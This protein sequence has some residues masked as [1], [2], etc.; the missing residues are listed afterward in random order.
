MQI[1]LLAATCRCLADTLTLGVSRGQ[2]A[3]AL[4]WVNMGQYGSI[5]ISNHIKEKEND[6]NGMKIR[7][8]LGVGWYWEVASLTVGQY[9]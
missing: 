9:A 7:E 8:V 1:R 6:E 2:F 4:Q 5:H 3:S